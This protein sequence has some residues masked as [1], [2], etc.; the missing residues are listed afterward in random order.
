MQNGVSPSWDPRSCSLGWQRWRWPVGCRCFM[1]SPRSTANFSTF[2]RPTTWV[3][4]SATLRLLLAVFC[5][6]LFFINGLLLTL[7]CLKP[8]SFRYVPLFIVCFVYFR[9]YYFIMCIDSCCYVAVWRLTSYIIKRIFTVVS[10]AFWQKGNG[11][12]PPR[13]KSSR[14]KTPWQNPPD[15]NHHEQLR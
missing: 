13:T 2:N 11:Q 6:D 12:K 15:K 10:D 1:S 14:L 4:A 7:L 5:I 3:I 9:L 8:I